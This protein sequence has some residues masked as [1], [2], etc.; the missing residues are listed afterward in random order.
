VHGT[1]V[2]DVNGAGGTSAEHAQG[3]G[4]STAKF[5]GLVECFV[6]QCSDSGSGGILESLCCGSLLLFAFH[7]K[8]HAT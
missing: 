8:L 3:V 4:N 2:L 7:R 5:G 6:A 1:F